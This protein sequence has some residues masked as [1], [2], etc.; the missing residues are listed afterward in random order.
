[1]NIYSLIDTLFSGLAAASNKI[2]FFNILGFT[3]KY[4]LPFIVLWLLIASIYFSF[5]I[6]FA[7]I[8]HF[9]YAIE[10]ILGKYE[11]KRVKKGDIGPKQALFTSLSGVVGMGSIS[12]VG[13]AICIGGPGSVFWMIIASI[14]GM[15]LRFGETL[16]GHKYRIKDKN[17]EFFGGPFFYMK[18]GLAEEYGW[19]KFGAALAMIFTILFVI[20]SLFGLQSQQSVKV[21]TS[22]F[23]LNEDKWSW[24]I[25]LVMMI[26]IALV[27][28]GG[29]S[30]IASVASAVT[31]L[32]IYIYCISSLIVLLYHWEKT[33][34][35]IT[36]IFKEAFAWNS[37][38]GGMIGVF[39]ISFQRALFSNESGMGSTPIIH[40]SSKDNESARE[41]LIAMTA[42][43]IDIIGIT[44][45]SSLIII[46]T[47]SYL[48]P[49]AEGI[50]ATTEAFRSVSWWLVLMLAITIP[51]LSFSASIA[52]SYYGLRCWE[53][54][55]GVKSARIYQILFCL[56]FFINGI[57][58][59]FGSFLIFLDAVSFATTI[60]NILAMY[61]LSKVIV[62]ELK[63]YEERYIIPHKVPRRKRFRW[64]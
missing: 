7:T 45:V 1:M 15:S 49:N 10:V 21:I 48:I 61:L 43:V 13:A 30:R 17:G 3:D 26:M 57:F 31:P 4:E 2:I 50:T 27:I 37:L 62:R 38:Y 40:S 59:D 32:M 42:P 64:F 20:S 28:V 22:T 23:D 9:K 12:G 36:L 35:A 33:D 29:V 51:L 34:E 11:D 6:R 8:R 56:T 39:L 53:Y 63:S 24:V 55:F 16:L 18:K 54:I 44:L 41:G 19:K 5:K 52:W 60:P 25:A 14:L 46:S 58:K 47:G